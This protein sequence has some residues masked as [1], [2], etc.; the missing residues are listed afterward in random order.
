MILKNSII[1]GK[2]LELKNFIEQISYEME[3]YS[4]SNNF[5]RMDIPF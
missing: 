2:C 5:I 4:Q 3:S 1:I